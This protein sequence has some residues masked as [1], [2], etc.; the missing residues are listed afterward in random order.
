MLPLWP[1]V[2]SGLAAGRSGRPPL[3]MAVA[4]EP[5]API[6]RTGAV[7]L[8]PTVA[9]SLP[10][11]IDGN[12]YDVSGWAD[13]HPGGR[14]LL[15]YARGRD[16]TALF[17]AVH[18]KNQKL[19]EAALNRLPMVEESALL[20]PSKPCPFPTEQAQEQ[21]LQG[22]YVLA[23][24]YG[25]AAP[26]E[27][28]LPPIDS[29]LRDDLRAMLRRQFPTAASSKAST[30]HWTRTIAALV[31]TIACWAG[32]AQGSALA[33]LLLPFVHWVLIAHTV[34]EATHGN[35]STDPRINFWAQFT[36]HPICF[37][38]FVWI[39]QH[40]LSHHQYTNDYLHDVDCHHF[41]P[42]LISDAQPKMAKPG[43]DFNE[44]WTF[45]WKAFLTTL[46]T[47]ILQ[48]LRTL[49]EK[50]TPNYEVNVTPVPAAVSKRMLW[51]SVLPSLLVLLYPA[52]VWLPQ[53]PLLGLWL[54]AWPWIGMSLIFTTMTQVSHV[55]K[56]TQPSQA[57]SPCWSSRQIHASLDYSLGPETGA[58]EQAL[59]T[60]LAAGLN[61]QSLHH[62]MPTL[63]CAHFPRVYA[64]YAAIC[65][66][67]GVQIRRS[68]NVGTAVRE[69]LEYVF[70]NNRPVAATARGGDA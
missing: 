6:A 45:V 29:P 17:H 48:P 65:E 33:C 14:W 51:L 2:L 68:R 64:E 67:H 13:E 54:L 52:V 36:S 32:W 34:H 9:S 10:L 60:A 11:K 46:G 23:G 49:T 15:E 3:R 47:S 63:S 24:L 61:A 35:L 44:G 38:V 27:P 39:P 7:P 57:D 55:Q 5:T 8:S 18:M 20:L 21:S 42:A 1:L 4:A 26:K 66:K 22:E 19:S 50:P 43:S 69:M 40:L 12:W 58:A 70:E 31:G 56:G 59:V 28:P 16:V 53:A 25:T 37:N 30:A 62:A 41:A